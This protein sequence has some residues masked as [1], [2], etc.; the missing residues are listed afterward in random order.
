MMSVLKTA[1]DDPTFLKK[2]LPHKGP[3]EN[4][5]KLIQSNQHMKIGASY[6]IEELVVWMIKYS[7]NNAK[8]LLLD[9]FNIN[10]LEEIFKEVG[11]E[12]PTIE[13]TDNFITVKNYAGFFRILFNA[14]LLN[15]TSSE[16][17]LLILSDL[18]F[19]DGLVAGVPGNITVAHKFGERTL[20]GSI[21][22]H[23][24]G[25]IYYPKQPYLLCVMT[26]GKDVSALIKVIADISKLVYQEVDWQQNK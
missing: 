6:T 20:S 5:G 2:E 23:D 17:A 8:S 9:S 3:D 16:K 22:L 14:S 25:I 1:E 24:C 21:Q 13:R 12:E 10:I 11:V 18:E 4:E 19:K 26:R 7:D 15:K